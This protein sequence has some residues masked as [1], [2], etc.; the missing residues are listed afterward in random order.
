M[1]SMKYCDACW[2]LLPS[3]SHEKSHLSSD[4]HKLNLDFKSKLNEYLSNNEYICVLC[5][6]KANTELQLQ[7]HMNSKNHLKKLADKE[8]ILKNYV[9]ND[10]EVINV[11]TNA[12]MLDGDEYF[13]SRNCTS[14]SLCKPFMSK[15]MTSSELTSLSYNKRLSNS[16]FTLSM[17]SSSSS[18]SSDEGVSMCEPELKIEFNSIQYKKANE[19]NELKQKQQKDVYFH[20]GKEN[21][22]P[23]LSSNKIHKSNTYTNGFIPNRKNSNSR[24]NTM[25]HIESC[26]SLNENKINSQTLNDLWCTLCYVSYTSKQNQDQHVNGQT[27]CKRKESSIKYKDLTVDT[28]NFC[29]LCFT[30]ANDKSQ[31]ERHLKSDN[32]QRTLKQ[33]KEYYKLIME[34]KCNFDQPVELPF[35]INQND[36]LIENLE[37]KKLS[38]DNSSSSSYDSMGSI[39]SGNNCNS[40]AKLKTCNKIDVEKQKKINLN[41]IYEEV[42][43]KKEFLNINTLD[44]RVCE[45]REKWNEISQKF[46]ELKIKLE[47]ADCKNKDIQQEIT[48]TQS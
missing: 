11:N 19:L 1:K 25:H 30:L 35:I 22:S 44:S 13:D 48:V 12:T 3:D 38:N 5:C 37:N 16:S 24:G 42:C 21:Y 46:S 4:K 39:K 20:G 9:N 7:R 28:K 23:N 47:I 17:Q 18:S 14:M 27:H 10:C 2:T 33:Y 45:F 34:N 41:G 43:Y 8:F 6:V 31:L 26:V 40:I 32:H 36:E 15:S 29:K